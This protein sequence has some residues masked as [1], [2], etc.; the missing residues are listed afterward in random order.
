MILDNISFKFE[1]KIVFDNLNREIEQGKFTFLI[2]DSGIGKTTLINMIAGRIKPDS[3]K[4]IGI[5]DKKISMV[6]QQDF[7][8]EELDIEHNINFVTDNRLD[9]SLVQ[10]LKLEEYLRKPTGKL[11][12]GTKRRVALARALSCDYDILLLDEPFTGLDKENKQRVAKAIIDFAGG[13]TVLIATH[14]H[15]VMNYFP[16]ART[17]LLA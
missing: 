5:E 17:I 4:I 13:K 15:E 2:G 11:S 3:G 10:A 14:D 7:L 6:F 9:N 12:G 8:I 16:E 1:N